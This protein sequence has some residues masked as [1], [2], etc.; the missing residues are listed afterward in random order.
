MPLNKLLFSLDSMFLNEEGWLCLGQDS[1]YTAQSFFQLR[2][3][4]SIAHEFQALI[5]LLVKKAA[6]TC[7]V[8]IEL[9]HP[10]TMIL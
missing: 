4:A 9:K 8:D 7:A 3:S 2:K 10:V 1:S 5:N 6:N